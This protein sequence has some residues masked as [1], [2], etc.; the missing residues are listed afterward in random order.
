LVRLGKRIM[1]PQS[2]RV[3]APQNLPQAI[4]P[5]PRIPAI[6]FSLQDFFRDD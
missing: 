4:T 2:L 1:R 5:T 3:K 6:N